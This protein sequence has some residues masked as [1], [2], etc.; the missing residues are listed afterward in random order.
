MR[1]VILLI[2]V[3]V[4][5]ATG[6]IVAGVGHAGAGVYAP[7]TPAPPAGWHQ[8]YAHN[9]I[10]QGWGD[11]TVCADC[12]GS[13]AGSVPASMFISDKPGAQFGLGVKVTAT[14]QWGEVW[15]R[16]SVVGPNSFV[17]ALVYIPK[18][19]SGQTANWPAWWTTARPWPAG[20]EID[21]LEGLGGKSTFGTHYGPT[22]AQEVSQAGGSS[23]VGTGWVTVSFLRA[24]GKVTAWYGTTKVGTVPLPPITSER[25]VF[26]NRSFTT[27]GCS[28][29][30]GPF[31]PA[32]AWLSRVTVWSK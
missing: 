17:K 30:F 9:F 12:G 21:A 28:Q 18:T 29:C 26:Q 1:K 20:G 13:H 19:A 4:M 16:D 10:T 27:V 25:L 31:L 8:T 15:S 2:A 14:N 24:G 23:Q 7:G 22:A 6:F 11:W 3:A 5:A 32:T